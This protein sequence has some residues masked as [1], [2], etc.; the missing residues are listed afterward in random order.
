MYIHI[1]DKSIKLHNQIDKQKY[2]YTYI[3]IYI[4]P[5]SMYCYHTDAQTIESRVFQCD[6]A[7]IHG[8]PEIDVHMA[9]LLILVFPAL[10][11]QLQY[12]MPRGAKTPRLKNPK[13]LNPK[14]KPFPV[15]PKSNECICRYGHEEGPHPNHGDER[16][17]E[18]P[19][20]EEARQV[21]EGQLI[22]N[23]FLGASGTPS[24]C[25]KWGFDPACSALPLDVERD[26]KPVPLHLLSHGCREGKESESGVIGVP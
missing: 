19:E 26:L 1:L 25:R 6:S 13:A 10:Q 4:H 12:P 17:N 16:M 8:M 2:M 9:R 7:R 20:G 21:S 11:H 18:Q 3:Y 5:H 14:P 15:R 22:V 23:W 24:R